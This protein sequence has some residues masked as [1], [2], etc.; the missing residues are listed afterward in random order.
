MST[1]CCGHIASPLSSGRWHSRQLLAWCFCSTSLHVL[2]PQS[3]PT[4]WDPIDWSLPGSSVHG[5]LQ[6]RI[7]GVGCHSLI[8]GIFPIQGS[9]PCIL[10]CRQILYFWATR[11]ALIYF[12][13]CLQISYLTNLLLLSDKLSIQLGIQGCSEPGH[14]ALVK[15][16]FQCSS[17]SSIPE[18]D[19]HCWRRFFACAPLCT[20]EWWT[21]TNLV[22]AQ[23]DKFQCQSISLPF[24]VFP[25][26]LPLTLPV[27]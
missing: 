19:A 27:C 21:M 5:I 4:L 7:L 23:K 26:C 9:D 1:D 12:I 11:E 3:C 22:E 13:R 17:P 15:P 8:Q 14:T 2:A 16:S 10:H 6:A 24:P 18:H 25:F 20:C